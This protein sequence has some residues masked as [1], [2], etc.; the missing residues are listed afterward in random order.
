M[1]KVKVQKKGEGN[2]KSGATGRPKPLTHSPGFTGK[3]R[4]FGCGGRIKTK[5]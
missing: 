4:R 3:K 1:A 2:R 5:A